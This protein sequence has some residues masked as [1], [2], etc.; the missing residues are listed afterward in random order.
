MHAQPSPCGQ[1]NKF[2]DSVNACGEPGYHRMCNQTHDIKFSR[3]FLSPIKIMFSV[4]SLL[5][6]KDQY[7]KIEIRIMVIGLKPTFIHN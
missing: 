5:N 6:I 4:P 2:R 7:E 1:S 3:K